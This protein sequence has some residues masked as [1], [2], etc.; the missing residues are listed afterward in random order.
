M[1][2][3]RHLQLILNNLLAPM[4]ISQGGIIAELTTEYNKTIQDR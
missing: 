3:S 1:S 4:L 2:C